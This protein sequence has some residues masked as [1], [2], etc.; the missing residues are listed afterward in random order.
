LRAALRPEDL[1]AVQQQMRRRGLCWLDQYV[2]VVRPGSLFPHTCCTKWR[3]NAPHHQRAAL[4]H[5]PRRAGRAD[6]A[7]HPWTG[8]AFDERRFGRATPGIRRG[9]WRPARPQPWVR[10]RCQS[11]ID[12]RPRFA[13]LSID[14]GGKVQIA[15]IDPDFAGGFLPPSL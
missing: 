10:W 11:L 12:G 1:T 9:N 13:K 4:D 14:G 8:N 7:H 3:A 5:R 2:A 6:L 15:A